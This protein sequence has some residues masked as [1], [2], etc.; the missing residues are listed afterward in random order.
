VRAFCLGWLLLFA[1]CEPECE[2]L[3]ILLGQ[4]AGRPDLA[5][6]PGAVITSGDGGL[7]VRTADRDFVVFE[8]LRAHLF[9]GSSTVT[10][11]VQW[12]LINRQEFVVF[13]EHPLPLAEG[14]TVS[15]QET[16]TD[17]RFTGGRG[18]TTWWDTEWDWIP[19]STT[20]PARAM[21]TEAFVPEL[22]ATSVQGEIEVR[23]TEPYVLRVGLSFEGPDLPLTHFWSDV[24][25]GARD[26]VDVCE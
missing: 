11:R 1:A 4:G 15:L 24:R 3:D 23:D 25:F 20:A 6:R 8:P 18:T 16:L 9:A 19:G 5:P 26:Q 10:G 14:D 13:V 7:S 22:S 12:S 2:S 17:I 21:L